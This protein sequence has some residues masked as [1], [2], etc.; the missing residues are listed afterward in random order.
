[1]NEVQRTFSLRPR[2]FIVLI[3]A[4]AKAGDNFV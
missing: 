1:M 2:C 4:D 3:V